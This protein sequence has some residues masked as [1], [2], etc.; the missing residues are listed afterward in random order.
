MLSIIGGNLFIDLEKSGT[1]QLESSISLFMLIN[2]IFCY[3]SI[4]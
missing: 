4:N 3:P 2:R 1:E